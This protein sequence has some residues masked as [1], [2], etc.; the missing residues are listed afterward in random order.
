[1]HPYHRDSLAALVGLCDQTGRPADALTYVRRF[2]DLD[3]GNPQ[4][5]ADDNE[6]ERSGGTITGRL[7]R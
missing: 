5:A 1:M 6:A 7:V 4:N 3:P 2:N